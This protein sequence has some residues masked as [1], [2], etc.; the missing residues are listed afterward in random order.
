MS[1]R[2][3]T[4]IAAIVFATIFSAIVAGTASAATYPQSSF[5]YD[6]FG[7]YYEGTCTVVENNGFHLSCHG[8]LVSGSP[9]SSLTNISSG[10]LRGY[11]TPSGQVIE[12]VS[13]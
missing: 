12:I 11:L 4:T 9:V 3:F 10:N 7:G 5:S 6:G 13:A 1:L 2:H 8:T